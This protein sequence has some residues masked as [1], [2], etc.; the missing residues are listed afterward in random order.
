MAETTKSSVKKTRTGSKSSSVVVLSQKFFQTLFQ[1][2]SLIFMMSIA[3][4]ICSIIF[5]LFLSNKP[6]EPQYIPIDDS[7]RLFQ[8]SPLSECKMESEVK[9]F[10]IEAI[11]KLYRYDYIN[12][13]DQVMQGSFYFTDQGWNNYIE[14]LRKQKTIENV[15]E[16]Q[17]IA[18]TDITSTPLILRTYQKNNVCTVEMQIPVNITYW[19]ANLQNTSGDLFAKIVRESVEKNPEGLAIDTLIYIEKK[20]GG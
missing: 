8:P 17:A 18:S 13:N 14:D 9:K 3:T 15:R 10:F 2:A 12:Y 6:V 16:S 11:K 7:G 20:I 19:G 1:Q 5:Y 4:T